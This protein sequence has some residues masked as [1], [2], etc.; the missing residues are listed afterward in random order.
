MEVMTGWLKKQPIRRVHTSKKK[1]GSAKRRFFVLYQ[2]EKSSQLIYYVSDDRKKK[3]GEIIINSDAE[4]QAVNDSVS[5][6]VI[7]LYKIV[8]FNLYCSQKN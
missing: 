8:S 6:Q 1:F 5:F 3:K 4:V 7:S 2:G